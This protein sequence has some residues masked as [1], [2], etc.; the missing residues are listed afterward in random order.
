MV[1]TVATN[2]KEV[3]KVEVEQQDLATLTEIDPSTL[4]KDYKYRWVKKAPLLIARKKAKGYMLVLPSDEE[5]KNPI[6]EDLEVAEDGTYTLGDVV[7]MKCKRSR[8]N[9]RRKE[10]K[11][12]VDRRL[13]APIREFKKKGSEKTRNRYGSELEVTTDEAD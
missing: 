9:E 7:L 3:P 13:K 6:G 10:V 11:R 1:T 8:Y 2:D 4:D 5:I 12:K